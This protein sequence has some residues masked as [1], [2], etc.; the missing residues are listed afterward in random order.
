MLRE[1]DDFKFTIL[2]EIIRFL[3]DRKYHELF[4][5]NGIF[6]LSPLDIIVHVNYLTQENIILRNESKII[7]N[8]NLS[9]L[10]I[11]KIRRWFLFRSFD[12]NNID[13]YFHSKISNKD[14]LYIP[15]LNLLDK[16]LL[17]K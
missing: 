1:D 13:N 10:Q 11:K 6:R 14:E 7:L 12:I 15:K 4:E 9:T 5:L 8:S 17:A 3:A 16:K 2:S